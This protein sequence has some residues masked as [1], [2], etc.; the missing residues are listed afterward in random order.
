MGVGRE[1]DVHDDEDRADDYAL[2]AATEDGVCDN[3]QRL[4]H[5]HVREE[6][7]D[8]QEVPVLADRLNLVRIE[9][10]FA[11]WREGRKPRGACR[12]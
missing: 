3:G 8:K 10:L 2:D 4:V 6:Q 5:D 1:E 11:A 7:C 12:H 9:L